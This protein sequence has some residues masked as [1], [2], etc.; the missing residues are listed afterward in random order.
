MFEGERSQG[1]LSYCNE[2][3]GLGER[4]MGRWGDGERGR[5]GEGEMGRWGESEKS[6]LNIH[7]LHPLRNPLPNFHP[8]HPLRNPLPNFLLAIIHPQ[9]F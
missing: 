4:E 8:L 1:N 2:S 3:G 7:P 6:S 5:G 9:I